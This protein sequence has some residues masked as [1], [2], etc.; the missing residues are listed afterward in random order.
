M[1]KTYQNDSMRMCGLDRALKD[2]E[3]GRIYRADSVEDM[4]KQILGDDYDNTT[5][6]K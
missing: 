1:A 5:S 2:V 4:F 6:N 3:K